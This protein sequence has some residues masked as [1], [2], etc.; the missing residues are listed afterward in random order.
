MQTKIL[1]L[2]AIIL[3]FTSFYVTAQEKTVWDYPIKPGTE[4]WRALLTRDEMLKVSQIPDEILKTMTTKDLVVSCINFPLRA[5][6]FAHNNMLSGVKRIAAEF[7][8]LQELF[9]RKDN[10]QCLLD[11]LQSKDLES[12]PNQNLTS[13][14]RGKFAMEVS[15]T[16]ALLAHEPVFANTDVEQQKLIASIVIQ[17]IAIKQRHVTIYS[18]AS[19]ECSAYLLCANLKRLKYGN[20][21]SLDMELFLRTGSLPNPELIEE[22]ISETLKYIRQ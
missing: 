1:K 18:R 22:L 6:F 7:N 10:V 5:D 4:A 14:E 19:V 21:L 11:L 2:T 16:E 8:G 15:L 9:A 12:L 17:N 3:I 13:L 20:D